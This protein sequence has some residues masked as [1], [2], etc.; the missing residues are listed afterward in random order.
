[1]MKV[2]SPAG[3]GG[4]VRGGGTHLGSR[5]DVY[6][7]KQIPVCSY[8][9]Y[10]KRIEDEIAQEEEKTGRMFIARPPPLSTAATADGRSHS[11]KFTGERAFHPAAHPRP[12]HHRARETAFSFNL[13]QKVPDSD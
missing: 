7:G 10:K 12:P 4:S 8:T 9:V 2:E 13:L 6:K 5:R 3:R 1:M 11:L